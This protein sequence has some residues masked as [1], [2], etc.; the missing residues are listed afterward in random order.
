[1]YIHWCGASS[2]GLTIALNIAG[3]RSSIRVT[4]TWHLG[5]FGPY[6]LIILEESGL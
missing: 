6:Y 3:S 1:M 4:A 5:H 2:L